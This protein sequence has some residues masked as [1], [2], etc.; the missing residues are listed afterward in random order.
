V[1]RKLKHRVRPEGV[2][3]EILI[4]IWIADQVFAEMGADQFCITALTDG[5]HAIDS[6]HHCGKGVDLRIW[7]LDED[8]RK[9]AAE[10]IQHRLGAAYFVLLE[11]D[12]LHIQYDGL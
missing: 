10:L 11:S 9:P 6:K 1:K 3:P 8:K 5:R 7:G 4:A 2:G 12:H